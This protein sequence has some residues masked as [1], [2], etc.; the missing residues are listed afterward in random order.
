[1]TTLFI[2][3]PVLA[4]ILNCFVLLLGLLAYRSLNLSEYPEISVP[5]IKVTIQYPGASMQ[6]MESDIAFYLEEELAGIPGVDTVISNIANGFSE[7]WMT[8]RAG[9]V[10][11]TALIEVRDRVSRVRSFWPKEIKEPVIEQEGKDQNPVMWLSLTSKTLKATEL[12]HFAKLYLKNQLQSIQ[13]ISS[14]RVHG[15]PYVMK[16][17]LDRL[18]LAGY[19]LSPDKVIAALQKN[20]V[21]LSAGKFQ[22]E[23]PIT[24]R[25][26]LEDPSDFENIIVKK[27]EDSVVLLKDIAEVVLDSDHTVLNQVNFHDAV[28]LAPVKAPDGNPLKISQEIRALLPSLRA[29]LPKEVT[30]QIEHDGAKFIQS[31][32]NSLGFTILEACFLVL[33]VVFLFLRNFRST[34]IPMMT[35]PISLIGAL[36]FVKLCGFSL[37]TFSLLALV[38]AV[39]LVVD[40]AIIVLENIHRHLE[41]GLSPKEAAIKGARE[42]A[43]SVIAM[44]LTLAIVFTPVAL[45]GGLVGQVLVEFAL[46]LAAAVFVSGFVALTLTPLMCSWLLKPSHQP[47]RLSPNP[48]PA[49]GE[50]NRILI[51]S[52]ALAILAL[53][54]VLYQ[55]IPKRIMPLE[56]RGFVGVQI[57]P[58]PGGT[59][60]TLMPYINQIGDISNQEPDIAN[61]LLYANNSWGTGFSFP[62]KPY[63]ERK[64]SSFQIA[65]W[66]REKLKQVPSITAFVWNWDTDL[67]GLEEDVEG[68]AI[69]V[70]ILSIH[71]YESLSNELEY[72]QKNLSQDSVL[73]DISHTMHLDFP[74]FRAKIDSQKM[75]LLDVSIYDAATAMRTLFDKNDA[76][77][78]FK[79][80]LRYQVSVSGQEMPDN[81]HE[82]EIINALGQRVPL[83]TFMELKP[84]AEPKAFSHYNRMRSGTLM[85]QLG[86]GQDLSSAVQYLESKLQAELPPGYT[87]ALTGAAKNLKDSSGTFV[88]LLLLALLFIYGVLAIQFESFLDPLIILVTVPLASFGALFCIWA[89]GHELNLYS[90]VGLITLIG[91]ISKHGILLVD[92]ANKTGSMQEAL[93]MRLRPILMTTGAMVVGAVPLLFASGAGAEARQAIGLVLVPGLTFGTILTLFIL[94]SFY[95]FAKLNNSRNRIL[96]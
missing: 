72:L 61:R 63:S 91:L 96:V 23:I 46:T 34:L 67:P 74:G 57:L 77:E 58:L 13:G 84:I 55:V 75:A 16:I 45:T 76:L 17:K 56:D 65:D 25:L 52:S 88:L 3:R 90:Q 95:R 42:I 15:V 68:S 71:S 4:I 12:M 62:L 51:L 27:N 85:A 79:D 86:K 35:I 36:A 70:A 80:G 66:L 89:T 82:I 41:S 54:I 94:P 26:E 48:S 2:K 60:Q 69:S 47:S 14:V 6:V 50:G 9:T 24:F 43:F 39:G 87:Y 59:L 30:L 11:E 78:F 32:L 53:T 8:F 5:R 19:K 49:T 29:N 33:L 10:I 38:L 18:K 73:T 40:D 28:F 92:F 93:S 1:M 7:T 83:S 21:S 81:L 20:Q 64:K 22:G 31:S 44:T 37:N